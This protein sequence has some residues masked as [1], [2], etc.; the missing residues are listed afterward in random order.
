MSKLTNEQVERLLNKFFEEGRENYAAR[1]ISRESSFDY[2][3]NYFRTFHEQG[4]LPALLTPAHKQ[5]ACLHLAAYLASWG[6]YRG[7][8]MLLQRSARQYEP[9]LKVI[10]NADSRVWTLDMNNYTGEN[11][12][13]LAQLEKQVC[14]A[15]KGKDERT[16]TITLTTKVMLGVFGN[17]L[18]IDTFVYNGLNAVQ[19]IRADTLDEKTRQALV[20]FYEA[21][22][23][24]FDTYTVRTVDFDSGQ[25]THRVY[26]K[27]KL[28]DM[29][30]FMHGTPPSTKELEATHRKS[31]V[32]NP[33][34][35]AGIPHW[36]P[37]NQ[38][39]N[40]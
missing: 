6:M 32:E 13:L 4:N 38:A 34:T 24:V 28:V 16:P 35:D 19:G 14:E 15:L 9:L 8:S 3:F 23:A 20:N 29:A 25:P 27:A 33:D 12:D 39:P 26:P 36:K 22:K 31:H 2:C 11:F 5:E 30:L 1:A 17:I 7:K 21:H 18:A 10:V 40:Q 37:T